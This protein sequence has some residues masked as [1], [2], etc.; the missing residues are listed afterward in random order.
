MGTKRTRRI[1]FIEF[2]RQLGVVWPILSGMLG[3]ML[4]CGLLIGRIEEWRMMDTLYFT[5]VTGLTI[6]YGDLVPSHLS[7]RVLALLIGLTGIVL[8]GLVAAVSVQALR[9]TADDSNGRDSPD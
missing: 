7:S 1:F 2:Y 9:T 3:I 8:T 5:F 4:G 6:G